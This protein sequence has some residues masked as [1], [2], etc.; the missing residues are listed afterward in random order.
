MPQPGVRRAGLARSAARG[1]RTVDQHGLGP[2]VA[3]LGRGLL[4]SRSW[5]YCPW[6]EQTSGVD[7]ENTPR[8][9]AGPLPLGPV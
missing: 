4:Q 1:R 5:T 2:L 6:A 9:P 7:Q 3:M 8:S